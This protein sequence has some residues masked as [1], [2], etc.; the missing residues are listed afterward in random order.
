MI[1]INKP[2]LK[3]SIIS[4]PR[5]FP[6]RAIVMLGTF[7]M[8]SNVTTATSGCT[9]RFI[10]E[11]GTVCLAP[12]IISQDPKKRT[13]SKNVLLPSTDLI[14]VVEV[15]LFEISLRLSEKATAAFP[16]F[17]L[18]STINGA[19]IRTCSDSA[20]ALS[21]LLAYLASDGDLTVPDDLSE[22]DEIATQDAEQLLPVK[23]TVSAVP[24]V[25]ESQQKRVNS[26]M[27]EAMK[28]SL[29]IRPG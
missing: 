25:S 19:H 10:I 2:S 1:I 23:P 28:E 11:D 7:T 29:C 17:D 14:C 6:Y 3:L 26:L 9:L 15:G 21:Q 27:E 20:D 16:K 5:Y 12:Q 4:R 13:L 24:E 22:T 18:R 8:S